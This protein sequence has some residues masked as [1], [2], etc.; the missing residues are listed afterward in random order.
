MHG[1]SLLSGPDVPAVTLAE[2]RSQ[3]DLRPDSTAHDAALSCYITA[4]T[5]T[6]Q[7][8][9]SRQFGQAQYRATFEAFEY[10]IHLPYAPLVSVEQVTYLDEAASRQT[11]DPAEYRVVTD[12]L[13]G[14]LEPVTGWPSVTVRSDCVQVDFTAGQAVVPARFKVMILYW[15]RHMWETKAPTQPGT[16]TE[17]PLTVRTLIHNARTG[18]ELKVY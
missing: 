5:D 3:C 17:V 16:I 7:Q 8:M 6:L 2:A 1:V 10:Q 9:L 4:A 11:L 15:V 18:A 12:R 13:P 14:W